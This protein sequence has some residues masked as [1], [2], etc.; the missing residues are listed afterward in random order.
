[1]SVQTGFTFEPSRC[2]GCEACRLACGFEHHLAPGHDWRQVLAFNAAGMPEVPRF[3]LS[4]ACNHCAHPACQDACPA[5]AYRKDAVTGAVLIDAEACLGCRYCTWACPYDAPRFDARE[6]VMT[7][8]TFCPH[9]LEAGL[10]PACATACPTGALDVASFEPPRAPLAF[11]GLL[12]G[13]LAP[14]LRLGPVPRA[15]LADAAGAEVLPPAPVPHKVDATCEWPL[16]LFT[17][18]CAA[19]VALEAAALL[20]E[21]PRLGTRAF[22]LA[23][24]LLMGLST[25][26][27][28]R[29][30]RAWRALLGLR[31]SWLSREVGAFGAFAG[32]GVAWRLWPAQVPEALPLLAGLALLVCVDRVYQVVERRPW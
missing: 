2:T 28:G 15:P 21:S 14:A 16:A 29:P 7:K 6:G 17:A 19:L 27:L 26:H 3:H 30:F 1:M 25:L 23:V 12:D 24:V 8:C 9:R 13:G 10:K 22:G 18:G 32:L 11:A 20:V 4:L 31:T 5:L